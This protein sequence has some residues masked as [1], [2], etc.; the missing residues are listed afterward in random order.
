MTTG[1][2]PPTQTVKEGLNTPGLTVVTVLNTLQET[3]G[4]QY[5]NLL[6]A[7]G[8]ARFLTALPPPDLMMVA[9]SAEMTRLYNTIFQMLGLDLTRLFFRN[10]GRA[11]GHKYLN[12]PGPL[13][14]RYVPLHAAVVAAPPDEKLW[15]LLLGMCQELQRVWCPAE[16]RQDNERIY[17][18]LL[19]CPICR[20]ITTATRPICENSTEIIRVLS[21]AWIGRRFHIEESRCRAQQHIDA[22]SA[23]CEFAVL[24]N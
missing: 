22:P 7:A 2:T 16:I 21:R 14:E 18:T 15:T 6:Q 4:A 17:L 23:V 9:S 12:P 11:V 1:F 20:G 19:D 8:L 10:W 24:K 13:Y 5:A 3:A